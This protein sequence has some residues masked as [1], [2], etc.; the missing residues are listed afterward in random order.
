MNAKIK[1]N[2]FTPLMLAAWDDQHM[3][4]LEE[5]TSH[6]ADLNLKDNYNNPALSFALIE[7][8]RPALSLIS[9]LLY[10]SNHLC[11]RAVSKC[12]FFEGHKQPRH[13]L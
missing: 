6:G 1:D 5:L 13:F 12:E 9:L 4:A 8:T 11:N 7:E 10:S 3:I 2:G